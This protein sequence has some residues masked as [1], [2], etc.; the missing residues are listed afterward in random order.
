[1]A[2]NNLDFG[3]ETG[4]VL[5][6]VKDEHGKKIGEFSFIPTDT[7]LVS[8]CEKAIEFFNSI[9]IPDGLEDKEFAA[10]IEKLNSDIRGQ[11]DSMLGDGTAEGL[12]GKC[13]PTTLITNGDFFF[14]HVFTK[15][16]ALIEKTFDTRMEK[17]LKRVDKATSKYHK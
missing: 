2:V 4:S 16:A 14:E 8:R 17:K 6:N 13:A 1:M 5:V 12:F 7:D 15:I 9:T 3:V 11:F 10:F